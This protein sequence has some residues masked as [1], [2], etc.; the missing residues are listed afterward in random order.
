MGA[1]IYDVDTNFG[2]LDPL[3]QL[4][5]QNLYCL[6][7]KLGTLSSPL[8]YGRHKWKPPCEKVP[9]HVSAVPLHI[10]NV[11]GQ[12]N[13]QKH[14]KRF[15]LGDMVGKHVSFVKMLRDHE[16]LFLK[17]AALQAILFL[18]GDGTCNLL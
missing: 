10:H 2:F 14:L 11:E 13:L 15:A 7:S 4:Y 8:L 3:P 9:R 12:R 6:S 5:P 1:S 17:N 16:G 18:Y